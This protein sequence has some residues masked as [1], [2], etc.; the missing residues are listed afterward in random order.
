VH[1]A[2]DEDLR[3]AQSQCFGDLFSQLIA[4]EQEALGMARRPVKGAESAAREANIGV[5]DVAVYHVGDDPFRVKD[6]PQGVGLRP[7]GE[8]VCPSVQVEGLV[9]IQAGLPENF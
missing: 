3:A 8:E 4:G 9:K 6:H 5:V 1:A 7:Q 2:L